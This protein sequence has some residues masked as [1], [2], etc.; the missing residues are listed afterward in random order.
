[1]TDDE[2]EFW[3]QQAKSKYEDVLTDR[4]VKIRTSLWQLQFAFNGGILAIFNAFKPNNGTFLMAL[5]VVSLAS[6]LCVIVALGLVQH[7]TTLWYTHNFVN[8]YKDDDAR[9]RQYART[10][11]SSQLMRVITNWI[12]CALYFIAVFEIAVIGIIALGLWSGATPRLPS[13]FV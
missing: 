3:R 5:T 1:M 7:D 6:M 13:S 2:K 4:F 9:N 12:Q 10:D 11:K 8:K